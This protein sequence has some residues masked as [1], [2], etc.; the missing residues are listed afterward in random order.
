MVGRSKSVL[1]PY[2]DAQGRKMVDGHATLVLAGNDR[3]RG[4]GHNSVLQT[5]RGDWLV[6]HT[7]DAQH[8]DR[9]RVLQ[10]RPLGWKA[11]WPVAGEPLSVLPEPANDW[12]AIR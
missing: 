11:G 8:L 3:W 5:P 7:Y 6:H 2:T 10:I 1:G 4:P 9:G 12:K